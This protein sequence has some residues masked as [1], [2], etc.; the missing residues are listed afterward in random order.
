VFLAVRTNRVDDSACD[1]PPAGSD[2]AALLER[3]Q[4]EAGFE[5]L[6]PCDLP[7]GQT[8][9]TGI[10]EGE[11][12]RRSA[13][14]EFEGPFD[15]VLRQALAPPAVSPDPTG[16][17]RQMIDL[18][19]DIRAILIELN[20]GTRKS[21]YHVLWER[22]GIYYEVIANGPPQTRRHILDFATSL[23]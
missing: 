3:L 20:D 16:A 12:S 21:F 6:Y 4:D 11:G 14:M 2:A 8:L 1:L 5:V 18:F 15:I 17:S 22:N 10:V 19:P 7:A 23:Q 9:S 13:T